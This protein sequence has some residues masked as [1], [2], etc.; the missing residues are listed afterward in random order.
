M[1]IF[2]KIYLYLFSIYKEKYKQKAN[3]IALVYVSILQISLVLFSGV[4]LTVFLSQMNVALLSSSKA[5]S[6]FFIVALVIYFTNWMSYGGKSRKEMNAKYVKVSK[7]SCSVNILF[8]IPI[9]VVF[10]AL[11]LLQSL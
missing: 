10:F 1:T 6:I 5:I 11:L 7:P 9:I 2:N 4:F 8:L 3:T